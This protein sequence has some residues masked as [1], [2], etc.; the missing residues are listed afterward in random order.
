MGKSSPPPPDYTPLAQASK[1]SAQIMAGLGREQL[2]FA[3][4]QY[5]EVSP[6]LEEVAGLQADAQRQQMDQA[7]EYYSYMQ[8]TFRPLERE[9][10]SDVGEFN[11]D[12]YREQLAGQAAADA[13]LAFNR[14]RAANERSMAS[15]GVNPNSGRF[16]GITS[17]SG[18]SQAANRAATM[19]G[20]RQQADQMGYAR[21]LDA[22]G[23]GRNLP[24]FSSAA[25][26]GATSA[27]TAAG[28]SIQSAGQNYMGNMAIGSGTI[29][30]GQEM[31]ISGL[32]SVLNAQT[33]AYVNSNDSFLGDVGGILGGAASVYTAF[34]G[35]DRS[36]KQ[37][38]EKV[39][40][41]NRTGLTLYEFSYV[42]APST[43]YVGVMA[44][45][46]ETIYP[47]AV[48]QYE[49]FKGVNY[50]MLGL[51]LKEVA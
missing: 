49:H 5:E 39:G 9:I 38:I 46:V 36:I 21:S 45:E 43:R 24:D 22:V 31:Q 7:G 1:E 20:T 15:M 27:G 41:D 47:E 18:L 29:G 6:F 51:E 8:D 13:G 42:D 2:D 32:S 3:R 25:Y 48:V 37:D 12:A 50:D 28:G 16:A 23:L 40:V 11:T 26:S 34:G 35:S 30:A 33:N 4:Q 44:D 19:T 10:V 17:A 14:T